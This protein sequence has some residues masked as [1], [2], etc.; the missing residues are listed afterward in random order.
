MIFASAIFFGSLINIFL[1]PKSIPD[2]SSS[3]SHSP[4]WNMFSDISVVLMILITIYAIT[5]QIFSKTNKVKSKDQ[6][7][8]L[9]LMVKGMTCNHCK[10]TATESIQSCDGVEKVMVDLDTG[11]ALIYGKALNEKQIIESI[12]SVGFSV[13]K[14]S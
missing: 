2:I 3:H 14:F 8:D 5:S 13:S 4:M 11:S 12:N 10:E 9:T 6:T 1:D 7:A